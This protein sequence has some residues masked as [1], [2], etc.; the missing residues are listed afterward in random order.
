MMRIGRSAALAG[1]VVFGVVAAAQAQTG[2]YRPPVAALEGYVQEPLPP[3]ISVQHTD[4]D[5]PVYVDANGMT[6]YSW[7]L[8]NL[9]NGNAGDRKNEP[10]SCTDTKARVTTGL[11]SPYPGG[12][13]LPD[14]D[15]RPTCTQ[16]W[17]P[18][19]ADDGAAPV[20]KWT[21]IPR[22][23]GTKQWAF[24]GFP[25][26]RSSLDTKP[27]HVNG[28]SRRWNRGDS[29]SHREPIGPTPDAPP[30]FVVR[31]VAT[32][33]MLTTDLGLSVYAWDGDAP[34]RSNCQAACLKQWRPVAAPQA[35]QTKGDWGIIERSPGIK[36][37]TFRG[38]PLYTRIAESRFRSLEG[39]D[40]AGW[41]NVYTQENP[42]MPAEFTIQDTRVGE[43]IADKAG[44]TIY[45]YRCGDDAQDQLACDH[46][47]TTQAYRMAVCGRGDPERCAVMFP[48]VPAPAGAKT[49]SLIWGTMY[50]DPKT[51][52][53]AAADQPGALHV[54]TYRD[55]PIYTHGLDKAPGEM[56]GDAWGEFNGKR[57]GY[58][59]FF[60]RDDF[61]NNAG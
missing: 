47:S 37:W 13:V 57:N 2:K 18:L 14:L 10:S 11:M 51:G 39:S 41:H 40:F 34:N 45:L 12:L 42:A 58:K 60:L 61:L 55:R 50:I 28:A 17:P 25:V 27:G 33:R 48:Y 6:L 15:I 5:G 23:D 43:V 54:W 4:V 36:Q 46:P 24:E 35:A 31:T 8:N 21:I 56:N 26:Y 59:G 3:G 38:R 1:I 9:R 44:K 7:P 16:A 29:G 19:L 53:Q 32:G 30:A 20:G 49:D 52:H 22:T